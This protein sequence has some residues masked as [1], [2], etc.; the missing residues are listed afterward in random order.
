MLLDMRGGCKVGWETW[1][2][3]EEAQAASLAAKGE[4]RRKWDLGYDFGYCVPG[5]VQ[6]VTLREETTYGPLGKRK[7]SVTRPAGTVVYVVT[8]P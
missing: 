6:E 8:T 5:E 4:A 2:S 1:E 3:A 7:E